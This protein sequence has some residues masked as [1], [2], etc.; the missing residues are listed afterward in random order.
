MAVNHLVGGSNPSPGA[1]IMDYFKK[2]TKLKEHLQDLTREEARRATLDLLEGKLSTP[3]ASALLTAMRIKGETPE[4]LLGITETLREN[5]RYPQPERN[6]LDLSVNYDGKVKSLSILPS[7]VVITNACGVK[8]TYH[9]AERVPVKEG[10]TLAD[11]FE[12]MDYKYVNRDLFVSIHQREFAPGLYKL[13][14]LRRELG[15]RTFLNVVEKLL[16]PFNTRR[17]ITSIFHKPY[18]EKLSSLCKALGFERW[19]VIKGLEGGI[20]PLTDRPTFF[21]VVEGEVQKF[22]PSSAGIDLPKRVET[23][24][25]LGESVEINLKVL[26]GKATK[27]FIN[28]ALLTSAFLLFAYG[29][30]EDLRQGFETAREG[31]KK[32]ISNL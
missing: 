32:H 1:K 7:A 14:P 2:L 12:E 8:L 25:V 31:Y 17:V 29:S 11:I 26:E 10:I 21:K 18:F 16:N 28:W 13:L 15:F 19:T 22:D 30:V 20:E 3:K 27:E 6:A 9:Y 23:S 5:L 24:E 4:E